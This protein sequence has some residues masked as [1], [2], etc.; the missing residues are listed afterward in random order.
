MGFRLPTFNVPINLWHSGSDYTF[1]PD[2]SFFGNFSLGRR[3]TMAVQENDVAVFP[4]VYQ[5]LLIPSG[6]PL[7]P[8]MLEV[9]GFDV[10][11]IPAGS[12]LIWYPM[13]ASYSGFGF[14]NQHTAIECLAAD[15]N[16]VS[17]INAQIT[18]QPIFP[19]QFPG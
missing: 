2:A 11:E 9:G 14:S 17:V 18:N 3:V 13:T 16:V 1:A 6:I 8:F 5:W 15:T 12:G 7:S 19:S 4:G 10:L